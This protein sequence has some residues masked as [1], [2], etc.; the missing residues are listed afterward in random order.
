MRVSYN[1]YHM[2]PCIDGQPILRRGSCWFRVGSKLAS[3]VVYVCVCPLHPGLGT[4]QTGDRA[5]DSAG[6]ADGLCHLRLPEQAAA[7]GQHAESCNWV[8]VLKG[9]TA[10]VR[11]SRQANDSALLENS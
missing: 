10:G 6:P 8:R 5:R 9:S 3:C 11:V 1:S 2:L 4:I 7:R